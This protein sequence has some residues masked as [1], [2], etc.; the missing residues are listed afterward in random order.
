M[1]IRPVSVKI[2]DT[3]NNTNLYFASYNWNTKQA[4]FVELD[5]KGADEKDKGSWG[6]YIAY[7]KLGNWAVIYPTYDAMLPQQKGWE[8]GLDYVPMKNFMTTFKY[9]RGKSMAVGGPDASEDKNAQKF[10]TELNFYF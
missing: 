5:Y 7:R 8:L 9:F 6:A 2:T 4:W 10:Y 1:K 3:A